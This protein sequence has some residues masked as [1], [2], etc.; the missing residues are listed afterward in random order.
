MERLSRCNLLKGIYIMRHSI[1]P[2]IDMKNTG[3]LLKQKIVQAGYS[4]KDIQ[5]LLKLSC[6]QPIYRWYA[7]KILPSVDHLFTLSRLLN[8][9]MD[10]LIVSKAISTEII[11]TNL[12]SSMEKRLYIYWNHLCKF[13]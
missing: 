11:D 12:M 3:R 2:N 9:H 8:V 7:G 4:V 10:D 1:Y 6:P 5:D 13:A